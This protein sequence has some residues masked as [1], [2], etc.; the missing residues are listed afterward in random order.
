MPC[1]FA[2]SIILVQKLMHLQVM[3]MAC[4]VGE[5]HTVLNEFAA[6]SL[7]IGCVFAAAIKS[8]KTSKNPAH[9]RQPVHA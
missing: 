7:P 8:I 3:C 2:L 5:L 9:E 6:A 4:L 1:V